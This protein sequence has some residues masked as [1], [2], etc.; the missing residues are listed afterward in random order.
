MIPTTVYFGSCTLSVTR[1]KCYISA[2]TDG[3]DGRQGVVGLCRRGDAAGGG[4]DSAL[5][6][7][8]LP[9][10][11]GVFGVTPLE[12]LCIPSM[13]VFLGGGGSGLEAAQADYVLPF[14]SKNSASVWSF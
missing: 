7:I 5:A 8:L 3:W 13:S 12:A 4:V 10:V 11:L 6:N 2:S 9:F 1:G 14:K